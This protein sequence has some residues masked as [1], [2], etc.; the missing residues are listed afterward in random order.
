MKL[1]RNAD[2]FGRG[3]CGRPETLE[4]QGRKIRGK[5]SPSQFAENFAGTFPLKIARPQKIHPKSA[6]LSLRIKILREGVNLRKFLQFSAKICF[7][8]G[9]SPSGLFL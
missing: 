2:N 8:G 7:W 9:L 5:N 4:K 3:F 6:L 1:E